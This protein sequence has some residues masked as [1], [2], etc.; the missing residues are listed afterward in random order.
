MKQ[1]GRLRPKVGTLG[2][3]NSRG[4][5]VQ[6][7]SQVTA[8]HPLPGPEP[9][10][11]GV[12]RPPGW[13]WPSWQWDWPYPWA[14]VR[15]LHVQV[16]GPS[17]GAF[18]SSPHSRAV[19]LRGSSLLGLSCCMTRASE[20]PL[21]KKGHARRGM[22]LQPCREG[23][24]RWPMGV[25]GSLGPSGTSTEASGRTD[26]QTAG[27]GGA[28]AEEAG[29][30]NSFAAWPCG[31]S[32]QALSLPP[33]LTLLPGW[34]SHP[35]G[36]LSHAL[37]PAKS[38]SQGGRGQQPIHH[39]HHAVP[40]GPLARLWHSGCPTAHSRCTRPPRHLEG[41]TSGPLAKS[42]VLAGSLVGA[43]R[44]P[45]YLPARRTQ[46]PVHP[47]PGTGKAGPPPLGPGLLALAK[48]RGQLWARLGGPRALR[49]NGLAAT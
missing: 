12:R 19:E 26:R 32:P 47:G 48:C 49:V 23:S 16:R 8:S 27:E 15:E 11:P 36:L 21:D 22:G 9:D 4:P 18:L 30:R 37:R 7:R 42:R 44:Q 28:G 1:K 45:K 33:N 43:P 20:R 40:S 14:E 25:T 39:P 6:R 24:R 31:R 29:P 2:T 38:L 34:P 10:T 3:R 35:G 46:G 5:C 41:V 17:W 13:A